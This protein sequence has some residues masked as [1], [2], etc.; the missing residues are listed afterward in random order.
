MLLV[1]SGANCFSVAQNN[2]P[3]LFIMRIPSYSSM[4][5]ACYSNAKPLSVSLF[6]SI[7]SLLLWSY[8]ISSPL[9]WAL[10]PFC[11]S[12]PNISFISLSL[13]LSS[14]FLLFDYLAQFSFPF[15]ISSSFPSI[16]T[17]V[18]LFFSPVLPSHLF[19]LVSYL[20]HCHQLLYTEQRVITFVL[21][22][23]SLIGFMP[24]SSATSAEKEI[25]AFLSYLSH[26]SGGRISMKSIW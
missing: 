21:H 6:L 22:R 14:L 3:V 16:F 19:A 8:F 15:L 18:P 23:V 10:L 24:P 20:L 12:H 7:S 1:L 17:P 5:G 13:S 2:R 26:I 9:P 4:P 25:E 11:A